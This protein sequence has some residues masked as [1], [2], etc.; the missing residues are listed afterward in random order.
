MSIEVT[1]LDP[2][3]VMVRP[4]Q[5]GAPLADVDVPPLR[6]LVREHHLLLLRG[7]G[8]FGSADE[9]SAY[10][11]R[12]GEITEWPFGTVL[13]LVEREQPE[14]HIF[15]HSYM[16]MHW[17]GMYR[18]HVPEF[19]VFH[20]VQ[21][22]GGGDGGETTFSNTTAVLASAD[23]QTREQ[24]SKV[25]GNYYRKM[26]YYE[27]V[28]ISPL[29]TTHPDTGAPVLRYQEPTDPTDVDFINHP[30]LEFT[31]LPGDELAT[32]HKSLREA[33]YAPEHFY[34]HAWQTGDL[35]V[36]DNYTL[37]HGR[38]AFTAHA[39]RHLR[40]VHVLGEPPLVNPALQR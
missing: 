30:D 37:L 34:A 8:T 21:A 17:D 14:D 4:S 11:E 26:E 13:E 10:A 25:T 18:E 3:G 39:P 31:G 12:W 5:A 22:P 32:V 27:S 28:C 35:V 2:F 40:R 15:D 6:E 9:L 38:N 19:Q 20:C 24:W 33:L 1:R 16:P 29:V 23:A 36:T 7:F